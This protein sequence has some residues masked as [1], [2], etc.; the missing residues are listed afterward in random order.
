[1]AE[2]SFEFNQHINDLDS[3]FNTLLQA[4]TTTETDFNH[5]NIY[6]L[7]HSIIV[8][9]LKNQEVTQAEKFVEQY[10]MFEQGIGGKK[11]EKRLGRNLKEFGKMF[12][13]FEK[14]GEGKKI[15]DKVIILEQKISNEELNFEYCKVIR[16]MGEFF[17]E[18][19]RFQ[20]AKQYFDKYIQIEIS[21]Q[22]GEENIEMLKIYESLGKLFISKEK[23][24]EAKK[25]FDKVLHIQREILESEEEDSQLW[26]I[27]QEIGTTFLEKNKPMEADYYFQHYLKFIEEKNRNLIPIL[28]EIGKNYLDFGYLEKSMIY[29]QQIFQHFS[30]LKSSPKSKELTI[31][32]EISNNF[33]RNKHFFEA[34]DFL[35]HELRFQEKFSTTSPEEISTQLFESGK[36]FLDYDCPLISVDYFERFIENEQKI[37]SCQFSPKLSQSLYQIA[38]IFFNSRNNKQARAYFDQYLEMEQKMMQSSNQKELSQLMKKIAKKFF[39]QNLFIDSRDYYIKSLDT[40]QKETKDP[41]NLKDIS[42]LTQ[43]IGMDFFNKK[44][45]RLSKEFFD[46]HLEIEKSLS[47]NQPTPNYNEKT[48]F[49]AKLFCHEWQIEVSKEYFDKYS[50]LQKE[51]TQNYKNFSTSQLFNETCQEMIQSVEQSTGKDSYE[52]FKVILNA[53]ISCNTFGE[54]ENAK[55]FFQT[56]LTFIQNHPN[57]YI[58]EKIQ[59]F[60]SFGELYWIL[61]E[62]SKAEEFFENTKHD[63]DSLTND[64]QNIKLKRISLLTNLG[65]VSLDK[66]EFQKAMEYFEKSLSLCQSTFPD[67]PHLEAISIQGIGNSLIG[68]GNIEDGMFKLERAFSLLEKYSY[69]TLN[70]NPQL[71][72]SIQSVQ[73]ALIYKDLANAWNQ[74]GNEK[75]KRKFLMKSLR[76]LQF[77]YT[78]PNH[79]YIES[80]QEQLLNTSN[81]IVEEELTKQSKNFKS[82]QTEA[83]PSSDEVDLEKHYLR[84]RGKNLIDLQKGAYFQDIE[85]PVK[86][87]RICNF[88]L[89]IKVLSLLTVVILI[90]AYYQSLKV[91]KEN[92]EKMN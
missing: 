12:I 23:V 26:K 41:N 52:Y 3:Y 11:S 86:K 92:K 39:D 61:S 80:L 68:L 79:P 35:D 32:S 21:N 82:R 64:S 73:L 69:F 71:R 58:H 29:F 47:N 7:Y 55:I 50:I 87:K 15:F 65:K 66:L 74:K 51:M 53:G 20:E 17:L 13:E 38:E 49:I 2:M 1:M 89:V 25:Y 78:N 28:Q 4:Q 83:K 27:V 67:R 14:Y 44:A 90:G 19:D 8:Y 9:C 24:K 16:E 77:V 57:D 88:N 72:T 46:R 43:E 48:L 22:G 75:L 40:L 59:L 42:K 31:F 81:D 91:V 56:A 63:L 18:K 37:Q 33:L 36:K 76:I 34:K 70:S 54:V 60:I 5:D 84:F 85:E 45:F 30:Q 6:N 62:T 10:R